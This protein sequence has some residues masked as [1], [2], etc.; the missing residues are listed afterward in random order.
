M[1]PA[2]L[3]QARPRPPGK[4]PRTRTQP[5]PHPVLPLLHLALFAPPR[6]FQEGDLGGVLGEL[7]SLAKERKATVI[8]G[9]LST[10]STCE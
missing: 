5:R 4:G 1:R 6:L 7:R 9:I 8:S 2:S 10:G 3:A